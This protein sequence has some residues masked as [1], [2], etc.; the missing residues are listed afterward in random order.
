[1]ELILLIAIILAIISPAIGALIGIIKLPSE[2]IMTYILSFGA[3][4]LLSISFFE[5]IPEALHE[6]GLLITI[7]GIIIG[8]LIFHKLIPHVHH[9][10]KGNELKKS[11]ILILLGIALHNLPAGI[12]L[13]SGVVAGSSLALA[14]S[15]GLIIHNI[16]E[17]ILIS[18]PYY[19]A[20]NSRLKAF[21]VG[22]STVIPIAIGFF[23]SYFIFVNI[24]DEILGFILAITAGII[25]YISIDELIPAVS[26]KIAKHSSIFYFI[27]GMLLIM[28][29]EYFLH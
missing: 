25:V 8:A 13:A 24:L 15:I 9:S 14:L 17:G 16:P 5:L 3:G 6:A 22:S 10:V 2:K 21:L 19:K 12:M 27:A 29:L 7:A 26:S 18:A 11:A 23:I 1:M 20:T 4:V 28:S